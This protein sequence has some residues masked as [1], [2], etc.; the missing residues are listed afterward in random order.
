MASSRYVRSLWGAVVLLLLLMMGFSYSLMVQQWLLT[1]AF[2]LVLIILGV[3]SLLRKI[4]RSNRH[5]A[6]FFAQVF[7]HD[8][9]LRYPENKLGLGYEH[10][11]SQLNR[12]S[13]MM[14]SLEQSRRQE[15]SLF[16]SIVEHLNVGVF[17]M[18]DK[19]HLHLANPLAQSF[20]NLRSTADKNQL[21]QRAPYF[22][23]RLPLLRQQGHLHLEVV[24]EGESQK[25]AVQRRS[26]KQDDLQ[27]EVFLVSNLQ[28]EL[29]NKEAEVS[30]KLMHT[31]THEIMNSISP[32]TS[33]SD[34]L[35]LQL[36][37]HITN[38]E[39]V[40]L[41]RENFEDLQTTARIIRKRGLGL[42]E[43]VKRYSL[44]ARLPKLKMERLQAGELLEE[45]HL[46][47][48]E[49]LAK[50]SL[51]LETRI[52]NRNIV[53]R[54]DKQLLLQVL[55]NLIKNATEAYQDQGKGGSISLQIDKADGYNYI[56]VRDHAGGIPAEIRKDIFLPFFSTKDKGSGIGLSLSRKII[57]AHNGRLYL[58]SHDDGAEFRVELVD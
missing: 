54:A 31:L 46:L 25:W 18:D 27:F 11:H 58:R 29:E 16:K 52:I 1:S 19:E 47:M 57:Q 6:G 44:L 35:Q 9:A 48:K 38:K 15:E 17:L 34:T 7:S 28:V 5:V 10:L 55:I 14:N 33:L 12:L 26:I 39:Q 45:L 32:I 40:C 20:L 8:S 50:N 53:F 42:I 41:P 49:E 24:K 37:G 22:Y 30:E 23:Q 13:Q 4:N 3:L 56:S 51:Q 2:L 21:A 43:F 36:S